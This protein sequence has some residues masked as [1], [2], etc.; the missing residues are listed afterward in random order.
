MTRLMIMSCRCGVKLWGHIPFPTKYYS[1]ASIIYNS[2][3]VKTNT[4]CI[5]LSLSSAKSQAQNQH[6]LA[7]VGR[8]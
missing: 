3:I 1:S 8:V 4:H 2:I 7:G 6:F 5:A